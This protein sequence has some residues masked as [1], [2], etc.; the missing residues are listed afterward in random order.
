MATAPHNPGAWPRFMRSATAAAYVDEVSV[1]AFLRKV[2][3]LYP[4]PAFGKGKGARWDR[5]QIDAVQPV[6]AETTPTVLDAVSV[7]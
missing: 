7:L 4:V 3:T 2:G 6:Q 5:L 1:Q